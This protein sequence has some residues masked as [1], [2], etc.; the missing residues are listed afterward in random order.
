MKAQEQARITN[1]ETTTFFSSGCTLL[2]LT[3]GGG[4][5]LGKVFNIVG[6]KSSGKTL[7]AI[8]AYANFSRAF[9]DGKMRYGEAEA[10]FDE[11][12][13]KTLGFPE[14]V[15]RPMEGLKTVED[16]ALDLAKF[17]GELNGKQGLYIL[18]SLDALSDDSELERF[19]LRLKGKEAGGSF[20]VGKAKE[21]SGFFRKLT[22]DMAAEN[23][24][25]GVISQLRENIGV[26]FGEHYSRSGGMA[27]NFYSSQVLWLREV[28]KNKRTSRGIERVVGVDVQGRVKKCKVGMP[29]READF[30]IVF[31]YGVDDETSLINWLESNKFYEKEFVKDCKKKLTNA[32]EKQDFEA[33]NEIATI[34]KS[35]ATRI[36]N[37]IEKDLAPTIKKYR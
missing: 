21:M 22:Q 25:L 2:D 16:F 29:F 1:K 24:S 9:K 5:A 18:D 19:E 17:L 30:T 20:G 7:L 33:L 35:D 8:E 4:W 27:L 10:A 37:E 14:G 15:G 12:F 34:L 6:D 32:R 31:G 3:L 23:C 11:S 28:G 13:A 36:W 26:T